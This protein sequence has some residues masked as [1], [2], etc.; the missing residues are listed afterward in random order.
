[1]RCIRKLQKENA[2]LK[3]ERDRALS[4]KSPVTLRRLY[5]VIHLAYYCQVFFVCCAGNWDIR[6]SS[7]LR[8]HYCYCYGNSDCDCDC[9]YCNCCCCRFRS[10]I[11]KALNLHLNPRTFAMVGLPLLLPP[12]PSPDLVYCVRK[13]VSDHDTRTD[14]GRLFQTDAAAA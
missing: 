13:T 8:Y 4:T 5:L 11:A 1:M 10:A 9:D 7:T 14:S 3:T 6:R 12:P 2:Q